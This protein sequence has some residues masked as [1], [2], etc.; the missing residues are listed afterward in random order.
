VLLTSKRKTGTTHSA[1]SSSPGNWP[2]LTSES[3]C[4]RTRHTSCGEGTEEGPAIA[5]EMAVQLLRV[6]IL[7][8]CTTMPTCQLNSHTTRS[9]R[10]PRA[11]A[12]A[13]VRVQY[14]AI[15]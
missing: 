2:A 11:C 13:V 4:A 8:I 7:H 15:T 12:C 1:A 3:Q 14:R 5:P 6:Q 9:A 10:V